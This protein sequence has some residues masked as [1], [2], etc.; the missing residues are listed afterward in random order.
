VIP[1]WSVHGPCQLSYDVGETRMKGQI[2][3]FH[4]KIH[5]KTKSVTHHWKG[6]IKKSNMRY[7]LAQESSIKSN[8]EVLKYSLLQE[9]TVGFTFFPYVIALVRKNPSY[10]ECT[11]YSRNILLIFIKVQ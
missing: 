7:Y 10:I 4:T 11:R 9:T 6:E 2:D 1:C 3:F 8:F 5:N